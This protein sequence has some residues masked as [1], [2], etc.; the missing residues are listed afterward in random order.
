MACPVAPPA[1]R[2]AHRWMPASNAIR[3]VYN[4]S[5]YNRSVYKLTEKIRPQGLAK[6]SDGLA[7][8]SSKATQLKLSGL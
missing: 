5:V 1:G 4:R 6:A 3:S 2:Y 7:S 8:Q